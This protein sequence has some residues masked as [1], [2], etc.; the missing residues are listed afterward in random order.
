M[1]TYNLTGLSDAAVARNLNVLFARGRI[2]LAAVLA[3]LAEVDARRLYL[4]AGFPSMYAYCVGE[5]HL[6]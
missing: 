6:C 4:P 5:L 2:N 1:R 3:Y